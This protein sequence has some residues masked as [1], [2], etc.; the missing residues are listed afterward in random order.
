[1]LFCYISKRV[2]KRAEFIQVFMT[3]D[4]KKTAQKIAAA[5][6]KKRLAACVQITGPVS[7]IYKWRGKTEKAREYL[8]LIKSRKNLFNKIE[9]TIKELH[10]YTVPEIIAVPIT[11]VSKD[12]KAWLGKNL[13]NN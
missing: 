10:T 1:M 2:M 7:S 5:L 12:Y 3:T 13:K 4:K 9:K 8:C 11:G 6:V